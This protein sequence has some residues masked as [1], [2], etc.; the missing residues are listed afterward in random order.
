MRLSVL[1]AVLAA[2]LVVSASAEDA[3]KPKLTIL[4]CLTVLK[5]L[6][7]L[8]CVGQQ[9][10]AVC[11]ADAKQYKLGSLRLVVAMNTAR[12][13]DVA[14]SVQ[15]ARD[16]FNAEQ[17]IPKDT[18][19]VNERGK[20]IQDNWNKIIDAEC[21]VAPGRI[22]LDELKVGDGPDQNAIPPGVIGALEPII[23]P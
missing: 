6:A 23:D 5:G 18:D 4:Q 19:G 11:P 22:K 9:L 16:G 2:A 12:L 13:Q 15:R 10:D 17:P 21:P 14:N 7:A 1:A 3:P 8:N 20:K